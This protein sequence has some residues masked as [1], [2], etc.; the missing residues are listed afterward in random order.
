[1]FLEDGCP[2]ALAV[3]LL[4]VHVLETALLVVVVVEV[5][6]GAD[7]LVGVVVGDVV[8]SASAPQ[9]SCLG[10][11]WQFAGGTTMVSSAHVAGVDT[12]RVPRMVSV[13]S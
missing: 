4:A 5:A 1:M 12:V 6:V 8:V 10:T 7:I 3:E 2:P 13:S 11:A 9:Q